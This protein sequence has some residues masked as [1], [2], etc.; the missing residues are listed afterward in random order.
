MGQGT[1]AGTT[2]I[3]TMLLLVAIKSLVLVVKHIK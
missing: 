2:S 1:E 3:L